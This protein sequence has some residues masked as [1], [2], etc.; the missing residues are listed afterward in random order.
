V[1]NEETEAGLEDLEHTAERVV[2][3]KSPDDI[4]QEHL[5]R[6]VFA[7]RFTNGKNVLD[8]ACGS[9]YGTA[10]LLEN[11]MACQVFGVDL[12]ED[13]VRYAED[14]YGQHK[15]SFVC[16][17]VASLPF[18][19]EFFDIVVSF[20]TIE[21]LV[22]RTRYLA[23]CKRVLKPGGLFICSSPNKKVYSPY[24]EKPLNSFHTVEFLPD[25][26]SAIL[27]EYF[28]N[29]DLYGQNNVDLVK[30]TIFRIGRRMLSKLPAGDYMK[31]K[32][33]KILNAN[34]DSCKRQSMPADCSESSDKDGN[35][36]VAKFTNN[37][38]ST[39]T[40]VIAVAQKA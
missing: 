14:R 20:E 11:G 4:Y 21:H 31:Y 15:I 19:N 27:C 32:I 30:R 25:Q 7:S 6:Y 22:D 38:F 18:P 9:G 12:S 40:F 23:E 35:Y 33:K 13:A 5:N 1:Y 26:F 29:V 24:S 36:R 34:K 39:P 37:L 8:A 10:Y 3:G 2:P 28:A 17:D 16:A